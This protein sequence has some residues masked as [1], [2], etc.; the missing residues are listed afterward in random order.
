MSIKKIYQSILNDSHKAFCSSINTVEGTV[1][2]SKHFSLSLNL[3]NKVLNTLSEKT[4]MVKI[5]ENRISHFKYVNRYILN[6]KAYFL[7]YNS[8]YE[9]HPKHFS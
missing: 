9:N 8:A 6:C 2:I 4:E 1:A 7:N 3:R 5:G